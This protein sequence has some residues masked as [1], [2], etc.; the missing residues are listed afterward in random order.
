[1]ESIP[2]RKDKENRALN[3]EKDLQEK[4]NDLAPSQNMVQQVY[5]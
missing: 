1:M 3:Q 4:L 5:V 2:E